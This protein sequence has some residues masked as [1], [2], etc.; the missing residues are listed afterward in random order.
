MKNPQS[1]MIWKGRLQLGD[2]PGVY[3]DASY[4]GLGCQLPATLTKFAAA[5]SADDI[6]FQ[7]GTT[8][9]QIFDPYPT[10]HLNGSSQ[11]W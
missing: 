6:T 10:R 9:V 2:E 8:D 3:G 4:S 5:G 11:L 7:V 1:E